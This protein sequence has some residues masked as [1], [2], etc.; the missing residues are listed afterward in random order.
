MPI[1]LE[2]WRIGLLIF[3]FGVLFVTWWWVNRGKFP[4]NKKEKSSKIKMKVLESQWLT[5]QFSI[6]L[7]EAEGQK[8]LVARTNQHLAWQPLPN[9]K[10]LE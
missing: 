6:H 3:V 8:F 5:N 7:I 1:H 9:K 2:W 4:F 10:D